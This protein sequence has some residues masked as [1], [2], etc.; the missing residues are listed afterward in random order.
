M[1]KI[2]AQATRIFRAAE[3]AAFSA[4]IVLATKNEETKTGLERILILKTRALP[5][6]DGEKVLA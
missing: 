5:D 6:F 4:R 3:I 2:F 1:R